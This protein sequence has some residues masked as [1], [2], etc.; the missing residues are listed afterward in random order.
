MFGT[1]GYIAHKSGVKVKD[2]DL[3]GP[4]LA[5]KVGLLEIEKP[6]ADW[7]RIQVY[8]TALAEMSGSNVFSVLFFVMLVLLAIDSQFALTETVVDAL[9]EASFL[10]K[11]WGLNSTNKWAVGGSSTPRVV[12]K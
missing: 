12:L 3:S 11:K 1:A 9:A 6:C 10:P 5:F 2:L 8:P 7:S 4:G